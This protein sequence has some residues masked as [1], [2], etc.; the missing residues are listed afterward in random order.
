[1]SLLQ[2]IRQGMD[3]LRMGLGVG[4]DEIGKFTE[5]SGLDLSD[6]L[7]LQRCYDC[8][9]KWLSTG[10]VDHA[11]KGF[12]YSRLIANGAFRDDDHSILW[13]SKHCHENA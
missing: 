3:S 1:M 13:L 7:Y 6:V 11:V 10:V 5:A 12:D 2:E 9:I 8:F 4:S